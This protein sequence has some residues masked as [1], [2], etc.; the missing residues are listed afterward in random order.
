MNVAHTPWV[1]SASARRF[2]VL[3]STGKPDDTTNPYLVQLL[4]A[5]PENVEIRYFSV[6][7]ALFS[8][9]DLFH[10]HWPEY[11]LRHRTPLTTL[12]KRAC[13][14][15][16]LLRLWLTRVPV[17]RTLHNLRPHEQGGITER[18]LLRWLDNLTT[19]RIRINAVERDSDPDTDT[20]LHGHY[21]DWF[22]AR[23]VPP[24]V[25]GR[26]LCFGLIRP[27]KGVET[28]IGAFRELPGAST[29]LRIVGRPV[30][31][32]MRQVVEDACAADARASA[33]L[34]YVGDEVL[35]KEIGEAQCVVL[36]YR[37]MQNSGALLLALS[38]G[39]PVLV[40]RSQAN[41]ALAAE[42]GE[43]W[44]RL[45]DG[46]LDADILAA[47]LRALDEPRRRSAPDLSRRDWPRLGMQHH[48][49]YVAA[50][51]AAGR[52]R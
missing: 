6:R 44:V 16:L 20:I 48:A 24:S 27:Y 45:Y 3:Q 12:A 41:A 14:F 50:L 23:Q 30:S 42:V 10:V 32:A 31:P 43:E 29:T 15:L 34:E 26:L 22:A 7:E 37:D 19:R 36:P 39:R 8:R 51:G 2:V 33:L 52:D 13:M 21:R 4:D 18:L 5:L 38:L 17:V 46:T 9:Y 47:A 11:L 35:A 1:S 28:L 40:P 25:N 49:T